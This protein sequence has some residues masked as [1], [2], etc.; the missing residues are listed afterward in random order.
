MAESHGHSRAQDGNK[1]AMRIE[2]AILRMRAAFCSLL[3]G[4]GL[5]FT[6]SANLINSFASR[7]SRT[8]LQLAHALDARIAPTT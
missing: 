2:R 8:V 3:L 4:R 6:S 1:S 5:V 7:F